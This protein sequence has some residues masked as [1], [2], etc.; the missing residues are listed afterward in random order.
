RAF[1][2][3][4]RHGERGN[5][6]EVALDRRGHGAGIDGVVAH[7]RAQVHPGDDHVGSEIEQPRH[8]DVH[9]VGGCAVNGEVAVGRP[10][11]DQRALARLDYRVEIQA[12]R[13]LKATLEKGLNIVRWRLDPDMDAERLKRL[14]DEAVHEAREAAATDGYF[15]AQVRAEIESAEEPWVVRLTVEPGERTRVHEVEIRFSGPATSD[16][17]AR[18][19]LERVREHWPLRRGQPFR[20]EEWEAAT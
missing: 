14:V 17:E 2:A 11:H 16:G 6:E 3:G 20:Q 13:E 5:A 15:S 19:A 1:L 8:R 4:E 12:P 10:A 7:I 18:A 9:A